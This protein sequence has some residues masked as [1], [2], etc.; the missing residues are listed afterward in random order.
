[1]AGDETRSSDDGTIRSDETKTPIDAVRATLL[2][3]LF[4]ELFQTERS[5]ELHP[6]REA[7]R[8]GNCPPS[9]ALIEVARDASNVLPA[10]R[11]LAEQRGLGER[12]AGSA[13][14]E[15]FSKARNAVIDKVVDAE[16]SY[17]GTL[18]GMRHGVDVVRMIRHVAEAA[19]DA[20][21]VAFCTTWLDR[22]VPLVASV[23]DQMAWFAAHPKRALRPSVP[24]GVAASIKRMFV[25]REVE[26]MRESVAT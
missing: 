12:E 25:M 22:R 24:T 4:T 15:L 5:A 14:G 2:A 16:R 3:S 7:V 18:A 8:L 23:A 26:Q 11:E 20:P 6:R 10:L 17:R 9:L 13:L 19:N 21:L 1:M